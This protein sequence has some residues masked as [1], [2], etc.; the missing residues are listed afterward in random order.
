[1][2]YPLFLLERVLITTLAYSLKNQSFWFR[3]A[4]LKMLKTGSLCFMLYE[5]PL[6]A[7]IPVFWLNMLTEYT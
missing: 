3:I 1:M 6:E 4:S 5:R 7:S 2:V